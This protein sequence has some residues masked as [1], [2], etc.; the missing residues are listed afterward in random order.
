MM[1]KLLIT[2]DSMRFENTGLHTFGH[3]LSSELARQGEGSVHGRE[4]DQRGRPTSLVQ[5]MRACVYHRSSR[6]LKRGSSAHCRR[7]H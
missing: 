3:S 4:Y 1:P 6:L 2:L 5:M 7:S